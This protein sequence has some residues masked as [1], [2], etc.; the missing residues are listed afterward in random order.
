MKRWLHGA[1]CVALVLG[2]G[3]RVAPMMAA[4]ESTPA[5][6]AVN[7]TGPVQIDAEQGIEWRRDEKVYIARGNATATRGNIS[8]H[9]DTLI[10]HYDDSSG[11]SRV[12]RVVA[13]GDVKIATPTQTVY[14]DRADYDLNQ[15]VVVITGRNLKAM[16][17]TQTLTATD[18]FEYW[19]K[20]EVV[21]ARGNAIVIE[22]EKRVRADV[23][24]GYFDTTPEGKR[25]LRQVEATGNVVITDKAEVARGQKAIY[26]LKRGLATLT[27]GVKITRGQNQLN[28]EYAEVNLNTGVSRI[29]GKPKVKGGDGR[30]HTLIVPGETDLGGKKTTP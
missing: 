15:A 3:T 23:L 27:G 25:D 17:P 28:G 30:V 21:V 22:P 11:S 13:D 9:S 12:T 29:L 19:T 4:T 8:L 5:V 20:R 10:A 6:D 14:G 24:T 2:C 1:L 18:R 26:D 16:T 7:A